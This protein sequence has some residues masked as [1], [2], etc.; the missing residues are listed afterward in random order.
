MAVE[1]GVDDDLV[2]LDASH[3]FGASVTHI[4][5]RKGAFMRRYMYDFITLFAPHL[6]REVVEAA[7]TAPNRAEREALFA[8]LTL[9]VR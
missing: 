5:A 1:E 9:P 3:L 7:F 8:D 4:G 6:T 2:S